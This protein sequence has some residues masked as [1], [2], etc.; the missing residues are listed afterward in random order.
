MENKELTLKLL[1]GFIK[2]K[3]FK[4]ELKPQ[5]YMKLAEEVGELSRAMRKDI[6]YVNNNRDIKGTIEE[7]LYDVLYYVA[8]I[9]N[10]YDIDLEECFNLKE[11]YN[12][13]R[14]DH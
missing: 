10:I 8:A 6:R 12:S 7:E 9:A 13:K 4:P 14:T 5:Y 1:Q 2:S 11:E 3:D